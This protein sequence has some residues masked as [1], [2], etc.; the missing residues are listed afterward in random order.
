MPRSRSTTSHATIA[1]TD[2]QVQ[3]ELDA[4]KADYVVPGKARHRADRIRQ[5]EDEAK[6]ARK[7]ARRGKSFDALAVEQKLKPA[8]LQARRTR[9]R[10][11][12]IDPARANA[13][14]A[15]PANGVSAPV[16]STFGWVLIH[17]AKITPGIGQEP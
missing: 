4:N 16:K 12:R 8:E 7:L 15:L 5:S 3:D 17:V 2:K 1:V 13:A 11:P 9:A 14:F 10:R 6:A